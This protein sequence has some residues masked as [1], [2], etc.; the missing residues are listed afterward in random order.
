MEERKG[1]FKRHESRKEEESIKAK[2]EDTEE[3]GDMKGKL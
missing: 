2:I 1:D 3:D